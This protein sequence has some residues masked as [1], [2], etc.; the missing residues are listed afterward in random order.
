MYQRFLIAMVTA[1]VLV[2]PVPDARAETTEVWQRDIRAIIQ[3]VL[4]IH[5]E[6]FGKTGELVWRREAARLQQDLAQLNEPERVVR[7]M[8]LIAM[9]GDGHTQI[10]LLDQKYAQWYPLRMYQF[11]DGYFVTA[12]HRSVDELAGAQIVTIAGQP[13]DQVVAAAQSLFGAD[14]QFD[15]MERLYAVH[16]AYLMTGLGYAGADGVLSMEFRLSDGR[17]VVR[18]LQPRQTDEGYYSQGIPVFEWHYPSEVYGLPF[19][20]AEDWITAYRAQPSSAFE[21]L[22]TNR[23]PY[24]QHRT[25]YTRR[26]MPDRDA[27]Y[28]QFNQ[29]DDS[30]MTGFMREALDEV[31][32]LKPKYLIIDIRYNFGGDGSTVAPMIRDFIRRQQNKS[33]EQLY[34]I[35]G[36]KTFSAGM[37]IVDA[38]TEHTDVTLVGEPAGAPLNFFGDAESRPYPS[39]GLRL[40]VSALVHQ[41]SDSADLR[42]Y[43]PVDVPAP[44][45]FEDYAAGRDPAVDPILTGEEM[46]SIPT[47]ILAEGGA[48]ARRVYLQRKQQFGELDW[49][50]PPGEFP[51]RVAVDRL[52]EQGRFEQAVEGAK[53]NSEI[54]PYIW[55]TWYNLADAQRQ[56]GLMEERLGSYKCVTLLAPNNWNTPAILD[57]FERLDVDPPV[58]QGCPVQG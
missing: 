30:G 45:S 24:M 44:M 19:D 56:A 39:L 57:L 55:N 50:A 47:V 17:Q 7:L 40:S 12:A 33:W 41:M 54:H 38:F 35:T 48:A 4:S 3:D 31:D 49:F 26:A 8:Q 28:V 1:V 5:P 22:D 23:S 37:A 32:Q 9:I 43:L 6:P 34:L 14:N 15:K 2:W 11:S 36:R 53:L 58:P 20:Q 25:L 42:A 46:R 21:T 10:E 29:T 18:R 13:V 52:E 27:Y 16:N 51:I